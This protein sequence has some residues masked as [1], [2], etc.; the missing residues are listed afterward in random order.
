[1]RRDLEWESNG[2]SRMK[3]SNTVVTSGLDS[4][5]SGVPTEPLRIRSC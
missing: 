1:V 3:E 2:P 4:M 5:R